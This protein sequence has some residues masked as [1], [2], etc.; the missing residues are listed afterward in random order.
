MLL[1]VVAVECNRMALKLIQFFICWLL[2]LQQDF[3]REFCGRSKVI[4]HPAWCSVQ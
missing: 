1:E 4:A 2:K 3:R